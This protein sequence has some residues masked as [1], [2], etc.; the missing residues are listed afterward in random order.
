MHDAIYAALSHY[1]ECEGAD[2]YNGEIKAAAGQVPNDPGA[3]LEAVARLRGL[4]ERD[5][6][7]DMMLAD[8]LAALPKAARRNMLLAYLGFPF[9]DIAPQIGRASCR[10]R[11]CP[12]V[13]ITVVAGS[14]TKNNQLTL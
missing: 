12:Y 3:A 7:A 6:A 13:S 8:A 5:E 11:V 9:Y 4:R 1:T 2:F 10:E 14:L